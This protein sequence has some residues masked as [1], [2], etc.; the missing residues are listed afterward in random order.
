MSP[1]GGQNWPAPADFATWQWAAQDGVPCPPHGRKVLAGGAGGGRWRRNGRARLVGRSH[2]APGRS[3]RHFLGPWLTAPC[4]PCPPTPGAPRETWPGAPNC[5]HHSPL[6]YSP[7][8]ASL[9]LTRLT[10]AP[11]EQGFVLKVDS[12][13]QPLCR[14]EHRGPGLPGC[15]AWAVAPGP[16]PLPAEHAA[17]GRSPAGQGGRPV[18]RARAAHLP[19]AGT[20]GAACI[21]AAATLCPQHTRPEASSS[22]AGPGW[23]RWLPWAMWPGAPV[24]GPALEGAGRQ[25]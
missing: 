6:R 19:I 1:F 22:R 11:R 21:S 13:P 10:C 18:L 24:Q 12:G 7:A 2:A 15:Q 9:L 25:L 4:P 14:R 17:P 20:L 3:A 8:S 23:G 5:G 16:G